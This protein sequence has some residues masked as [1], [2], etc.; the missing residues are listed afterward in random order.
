MITQE[1]G[2]R[3]LSFPVKNRK[4]HSVVAGGEL[5]LAP[6][7]QEAG[8]GMM[9]CFAASFLFFSADVTCSLHVTNGHVVKGLSPLPTF[10]GQWLYSA[11]SL[12]TCIS[13]TLTV[14]SQMD[15]KLCHLTIRAG[16]SCGGEKTASRTLFSATVQRTVGHPAFLHLWYPA[17][18]YPELPV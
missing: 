17:P 7:K 16:V 14:G 3:G 11:I 13:E 10:L 2:A 4:A 8:L 6:G 18:L 9:V 1:E 5:K 12:K 15:Y